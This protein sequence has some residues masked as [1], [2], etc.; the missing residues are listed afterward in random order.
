MFE[1]LAY[2]LSHFFDLCR[3][4]GNYENCPRYCCDVV[5]IAYLR[6]PVEIGDTTISNKRSIC[7]PAR[8]EVQ[9]DMSNRG[10][11][12]TFLLLILAIPAGITVL[13]VMHFFDL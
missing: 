2:F 10:C 11:Q 8:W 1:P 4:D 12:T 3:H 6:D 7:S 5:A 13:L 9:E